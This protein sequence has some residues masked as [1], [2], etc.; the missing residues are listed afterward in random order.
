VKSDFIY[1][2]AILRDTSFRRIANY[3]A[4]WPG[5]WLS[6][7]FGKPFVFSSPFALSVEPVRGCNLSCSGC[8][9]GGIKSNELKYISPD[10]FKK[11][12]DEV[13][14]GVFYLQLWFQGEPLLHPQIETLIQH[15]RLRKMFVVIATNGI[16]LNEAVC[17]TLVKSGL[18]KIII[19]ID[20]PGTNGDFSVGGNYNQALQNLVTLAKI[21]QKHYTSFPLIEAQMIVTA[22]NETETKRFKTEMKAAGANKAKLKSAWFPD[23]N[24]KDLP[25]PGKHSRYRKNDDGS[26]R[27]RK[28]LRN[29]CSRIFSTMVVTYSGDVV[30]C[31]FDKNGNYI[32]GNIY[33]KP[34]IKIWKGNKFN[35]FRQKILSKRKY[36]DIC[37]N[38]TE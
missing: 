7:L 16:L 14:S 27:S 26:W 4:Y 13:S 20:V 2:A 28:T 19:S 15:A 35:E 8:P 32:I 9:A 12:T 10:L 1:I 18:Q 5:Y 11:I 17:E 29:R 34:L 38:C 21:K 25:V 23:L 36:V 24:N 37:R 22:D 6:L 3:L 31:C 30:T 33:D